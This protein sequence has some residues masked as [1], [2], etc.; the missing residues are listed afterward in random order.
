MRIVRLILIVLAFSGAPFHSASTKGALD[1]KSDVFIAKSEALS[2]HKK[3]Y[4]KLL[5]HS[6]GSKSVITDNSFF[7]AKDGETNPKSELQQTIKGFFRADIALDNNHPI[8]RYPA[9]L[10]WLTQELQIT[11]NILPKANCSEFKT[12][13]KKT[14]PHD[15]HLVFASE[16]VNNLVS[17]MGHIFLK[18]S[19]E[20]DGVEVDHSLS[21]SANYSAQNG[22]AFIFGALFS[23]VSGFFVLEPYHNKLTQYNNEQKRSIWEYKLK[24]TPD[25]INNLA[26]HIW[27]MKGI[28]TKYHFVTHN[29][30][31]AILY[32]LYMA[33][34]NL[35]KLYSPL[36]A[37]LDIVK[38]LDRNN[39][40][41]SVDVWPAD[42]YKFRMISNNFSETDRKIIKEFLNNG[43]NDI[44]NQYSS[45]QK[46]ANAIYGARTVLNYKL[47]DK[48]IN[49]KNYDL[50]RG[51]IDHISEDLTK[52]NLIYDVKDPL[53]KSD[54]SILTLGYQNQT[55]NKSVINFGFY[56]V[57]NNFN[58]NNSEYFNEYALQLL[59]LKGIYYV[60]QHKAKFDNVDIINIKSIVPN[61]SLVGGL[62]GS[63]K[64]NIEREKFD[65]ESNKM[66]PNTTF[67]IGIGKQILNNKILFYGMINGGY[68]Y[69]RSNN[70]LYSNPEIGAILKEGKYGKLDTKYT[71]YFSSNLYKYKEIISVNQT[72]FLKED[73]DIMLS[74]QKNYGG[75][76]KDFRTL[77]LEYQYHF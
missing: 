9:R 53:K 30:G 40:I 39:Y 7:L 51:K 71:K 10:K 75:I 12:Y 38:N 21:Y 43:D 50:L 34:P 8:C 13:L 33:D 35:Q 74:Y 62:S 70:I 77:S 54:S 15:I 14:S 16:N 72:F 31:S 5:L 11:Q 59:N 47:V 45:P 65:F 37:P 76:E 55:D 18:I 22:L 60:D 27:E 24:F 61:D 6:N 4:W 2:L 48:D 23:G 46:K 1:Q 63:F 20:K 69:F 57:Y 32:L 73:N 66:F 42:N 29:C 17:M 52:N 19:G 25:Q 41:Q 49:Q 36:D 67:G 56:P 28:N 3:E 58:G 44:F 64:I 68:S 26:L